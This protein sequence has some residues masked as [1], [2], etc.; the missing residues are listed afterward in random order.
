MYEEL[1][2]CVDR[3][4]AQEVDSLLLIENTKERSVALL[5]FPSFPPALVSSDRL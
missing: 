4:Q 5:T 1:L 3:G 2:N